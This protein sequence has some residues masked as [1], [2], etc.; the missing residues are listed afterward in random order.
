MSVRI[1]WPTCQYSSTSAEL[2]PCATVWRV[3]AISARNSAS[4][5]GGLVA[6]RLTLLGS[7][8]SAG[9]RARGARVALVAFFVVIGWSVSWHCAH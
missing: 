4:K 5:E 7:A 6:G 1:R 3:A 9:L 8:T 2:T